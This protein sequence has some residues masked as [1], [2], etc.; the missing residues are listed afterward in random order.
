MAGAIPPH[1]DF[2]SPVLKSSPAQESSRLGAH[3]LLQGLAVPLLGM[4]VEWHRMAVPSL[5]VSPWLARP[6][7]LSTALALGLHC[8]FLCK[9]QEC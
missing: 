3:W 8:H 4:A 2:P 7:I 1:S 5:T 9:L 6:L